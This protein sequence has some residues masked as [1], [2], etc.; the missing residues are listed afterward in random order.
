MWPAFLT[1][2]CWK[3][4][5]FLAY[6]ASS[7]PTCLKN[8][9]N[10][11]IRQVSSMIPSA[12]PTIPSVAITIF[13][14]ENCFVLLDLEEHSR[15]DC[16]MV[17]QKDDMCEKSDHHCRSWLWVSPMDK[18]KLQY[19]LC[20]VELKLKYFIYHLVLGVDMYFFAPLQFIEVMKLSVR[21]HAIMISIWP[22]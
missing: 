10:L 14:H 12:R 1:K 17:G 13:T 20:T 9:W 18:K 2:T 7:P 16:R 3:L 4:P 15:T 5:T 6:P 22:L 19:V 11:K 21:G 8:K